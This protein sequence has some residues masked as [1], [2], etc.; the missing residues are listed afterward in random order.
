M[1]Q[2]Y[3]ARKIK[4]PNGTFDSKK[5]YERY[6]HLKFQADRGIITNLQLQ[7]QFEIIPKLTRK[8]KV[9][10]KT[11]IKEV[12]RTEELAAHYTADFAY[13]NHNGQIVIE[14]V[15]SKGTILARDYPL[16]RKLIKQLLAK[17]N[18]ESGKELYVFNE[19]I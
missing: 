12:E 16:R 4:T 2:K 7:P 9:Q 14:E 13:I 5:E 10:L 11:K 1:E 18:E 17:W 3:F 15:K 6:L 8:V 19:I